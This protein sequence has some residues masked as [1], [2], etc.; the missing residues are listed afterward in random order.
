MKIR[1]A[2][3]VKES[4]VDG[5]GLRYV[6]FVQGCKHNCQGC[7]NPKT[8][9]F[10]GGYLIE[11]DE[12]IKEIRA[13]PLI[14][15]MT[16]SGGEPLEQPKELIPLI[17]KARDLNKNIIIYTGYTYEAIQKA[18]KIRR[19]WT[20]LL[21]LTDILIDGPFQKD[22]EDPLLKFRGSQNQRIIDVKE[23]LRMNKA[24]ILEI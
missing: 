13:N 12:I 23:S 11:I 6:V 16:I 21:E 10:G 15:G 17:Q 4:I 24:V 19:E 5:P 14:D 3:L 7:H 1:V 22:K 8:H 20:T 18:G 9:D 2:G